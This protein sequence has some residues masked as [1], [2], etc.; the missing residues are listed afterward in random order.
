MSTNNNDGPPEIRNQ[1]EFENTQNRKS[2]RSKTTKK[3]TPGRDTTERT[4]PHAATRCCGIKCSGRRLTEDETPRQNRPTAPSPAVAINARLRARK[5]QDLNA[6]EPQTARTTPGRRLQRM[7]R[8]QTRQRLIRP[9]SPKR[10]LVG[11]GPVY[12]DGTPSTV[13]PVR[14]GRGSPTPDSLLLRWLA[15]GD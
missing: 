7:T 5:S 13:I 9:D 2:D 15:W 10:R 1:S 11:S 8:P 6:I 14:A 4:K 12:I 3:T